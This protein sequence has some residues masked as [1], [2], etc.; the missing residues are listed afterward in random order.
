MSLRFGPHCPH[1]STSAAVVGM[2]CQIWS[3]RGNREAADPH[4]KLTNA[5]LLLSHASGQSHEHPFLYLLLC[6]PLAICTYTTCCERP[7]C[8]RL[9]A[10]RCD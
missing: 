6:L 5:V 4:V 10:L 3:N 7:D 9:F 2:I 1:H 8:T